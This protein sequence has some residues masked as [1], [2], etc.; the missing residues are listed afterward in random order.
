[1]RPFGE[2]PLDF[3]LLYLALYTCLVSKLDECSVSLLD[4]LDTRLTGLLPLEH[5]KLMDQLQPFLS[6]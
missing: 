2:C 4:Y 6:L 5:L 1:M 3:L